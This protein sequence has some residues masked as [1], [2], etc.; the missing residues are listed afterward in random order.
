M[1]KIGVVSF[2]VIACL[3]ILEFS[4]RAVG[5][6]PTNMADGTAEQ[7]GDSF[8]LKKNVAKVIR[9]PA[10]TYTV[11]TNE[12]GFRDRS[13]GPRELKGRPF[14]AVLGASE[15][16]G[17]G[18][19][20]EDSFVGIFSEEAKKKGMEVVNLAVG[21]YGFLD[22]EDL[23]KKFMED[24]GH[25]P[26]VV[27]FCVNALHISGFDRRS[28]NVIVKSGYPIDRDGWR[29]TYLRLLAGNI[30]SAYCFFRDGIRRIQEKYLNYLVSSKSPEFIR[31]FSRANSIRKP[32][33]IKE[34][35]DY[36]AGFEAFCRQN[37]IGLIYV[38]LPLSDS[39]RL[40]D[41]V[42]QIGDNPDDYDAS[43]YETLMRS[44]CEK[45]GMKL[46]DLHPLLQQH[47]DEGHELRFKLDPHFNV[48]GNRV[49]GEFLI[50]ALL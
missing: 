29:I 25:K 2:T 45:I 10:Y 23:L 32:E 40:K 35:D 7:F 21:G 5:R 6:W 44:H 8:R 18:V 26:A 9:Y 33:R 3:I 34:F 49:I 37:G 41:I 24:T 46:V 27:L 4:L 1:K 19:E 36:L 22:Q 48:F 42:R 28:R 17:N 12:F 30:S 14:Y 38:H 39:F 13:T 43:F 11:Y 20:Y 47:Y 31:A 16:F 50:K 15:V